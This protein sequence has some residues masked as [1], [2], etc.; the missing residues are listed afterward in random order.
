MFKLCPK[1]AIL[2]WNSHRQ[3]TKFKK[4]FHHSIGG[5]FLLIKRR[6]K[7]TCS[8]TVAFLSFQFIC[9]NDLNPSFNGYTRTKKINWNMQKNVLITNWISIW[10]YVDKTS[11]GNFAFKNWLSQKSCTNTCVYVYSV[12]CICLFLL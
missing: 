11:D 10:S 5:K 8:T 4:L 3:W 2:D 1:N 6:E 12:F 7:P 9:E